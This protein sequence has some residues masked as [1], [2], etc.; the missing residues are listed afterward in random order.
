V[1]FLKIA[2]T[3]NNMAIFQSILELFGGLIIFMYGVH[4]LSEGLEK[5][6]GSHLLSLLEKSTDHPLKAGL[7]GMLAT[8]LMQ[9]SGLLMVTMIGL[10]NAN[11]LSLQHAIGIM[12]GQEIGTTITGQL[13]SFQ[14][15][16]LNLVFLIAGFYLMFFTKNRKLQLFGMPLFGFGV[17]FV[18]MNMMS[19]AGTVV[20]QTPFFQ[21]SLLLMSRHIFGDRHGHKQQH[22]AAGSGCHHPRREYWFMYYGLARITA[23]RI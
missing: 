3:I 5:V 13:I 14:I 22:L 21:E 17:V 4:L 2:D 20:S 16:G 6:G 7:F 23:V 9:S 15:R 12:L 1:V 10:I 8:A 19:K 18:G 11:L